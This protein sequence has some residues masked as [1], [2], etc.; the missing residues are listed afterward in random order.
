MFIKAF[1]QKSANHYLVSTEYHNSPAKRVTSPSWGQIC[2]GGGRWA[3]MRQQCRWSSV[4]KQAR[5]TGV[6]PHRP[7][8]RNTKPKWKVTEERPH[9]GIT[10]YNV[11]QPEREQSAARTYTWVCVVSTCGVQA[12][13]E[14]DGSRKKRKRKAPERRRLFGIRKRHKFQAKF[15]SQLAT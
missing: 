4:S 9:F 1:L 3:G 11:E 6:N 14:R 13:R 5:Q 2:E 15:Y 12:R 10:G 8:S 7:R